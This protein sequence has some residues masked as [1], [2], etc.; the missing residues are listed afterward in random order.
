MSKSKPVQVPQ[1]LMEQVGDR[2]RA[3]FID[4]FT[5][6]K[7]LPIPITNKGFAMFLRG[8]AEEIESIDESNYSMIWDMAVAVST[9]SG[10]YILTSGLA[11][12]V[13]SLKEG[14]VIDG[15]SLKPS[16]ETFN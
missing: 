15:T 14:S 6:D 13:A 5:P 12:G 2:L 16:D 7:D 11:G 10:A 4:F 1:D 9:I 3:S 8:M